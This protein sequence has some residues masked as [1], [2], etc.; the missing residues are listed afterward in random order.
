MSLLII[1]SVYKVSHAYLHANIIE[2]TCGLI[3]KA[4][5]WNSISDETPVV[6]GSVH[7]EGV[8]FITFIG[9]KLRGTFFP[10]KDTLFMMILICFIF[11][12][13][14]FCQ[15]EAQL[16]SDGCFFPYVFLV[17]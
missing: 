11:R 15:K 12:V 13:C 4:L 14:F 17:F 9:K 5:L 2:R 10:R 16:H 3:S 8:F 6:K 7:E 1:L